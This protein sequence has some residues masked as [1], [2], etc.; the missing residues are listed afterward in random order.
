MQKVSTATPF[1][2]SPPWPVVGPEDDYPWEKM[3]D[4]ERAFATQYR[5]FG[6]DLPH[7]Y[8]NYCFHAGRKWR[9]DFVDPARH[10]GIELEGMR[11]RQV[12]CHNCGSVVR[13]KDKSG[14]LGAA[15]VV[16]GF[17][18]RRSRFLGDMEKYNTAA[19]DGYLLLRFSHDDV[20][21]TPMDMVAL[22]RRAIES[23]PVKVAVT[24]HLSKAEKGVL[25]LVAAGFDTAQIGDR[26]G[27][28]P[29][30][31]RNQV[32]SICSRL[33]TRNRAGAVARALST[34]E[35]VADD[36]P[37]PIGLDE[38]LMKDVE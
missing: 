36:I 16:A 2:P 21:G 11:D 27:V 23:R 37:W 9:M 31:I 20:Y 1:N 6:R 22:I 7:L 8:Y 29:N 33:G 18:G 3:S 28:S 10:V 5:R 32:A 13:A 12:V 15:I 38:A 30:T 4:L 25:A 26:L 19:L 14:N 24:N 34:G 35:I 17:H